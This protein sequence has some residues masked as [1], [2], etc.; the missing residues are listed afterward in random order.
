M[1]KNYKQKQRLSGRCF[2]FLT[3]PAVSTFYLYKLFS[4]SD[5]RVA[6][7]SLKGVLKSRHRPPDNCPH[8]SVSPSL[9][10]YLPLETELYAF[11]PELNLTASALR[12]NLHQ[13]RASSISST[14]HAR[15]NRSLHDSGCFLVEMREF[16]ASNPWTAVH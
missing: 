1:F 13:T 12:R 11:S 7:A 5:C 2:C 4:I 9:E 6:L 15:G 10:L 14:Q 3:Q 8:P 16:G